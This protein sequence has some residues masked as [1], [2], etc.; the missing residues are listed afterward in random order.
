MIRTPPPGQQ[1][2]GDQRRQD[3][4]TQLAVI[5][6]ADSDTPV[7]SADRPDDSS[8]ASIRGGISAEAESRPASGCPAERHSPPT[9]NELLGKLAG[10]S[11]T[12]SSRGDG[13]FVPIAPD[14]FSK[15]RLTEAEV[16]SLILKFL[17]NC[18]DATGQQIAGQIGISFCI[19]RSCCTP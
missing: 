2:W 11:S 3:L 5:L 9:P 14:E 10:E 13:E 16:E 18:Q 17:L 6:Q 4:L 8:V 1:E 19:A 7:D 12:E 15:L